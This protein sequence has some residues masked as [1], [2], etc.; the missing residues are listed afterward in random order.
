M[1]MYSEQ[2]ETPDELVKAMGWIWD[3]ENKYF[4]HPK[5][6]Q[7]LFNIFKLEQSKWLVPLYSDT[8]VVDKVTSRTFKYSLNSSG[9]SYSLE[10]NDP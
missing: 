1:I 3:E 9:N 7:F 4:K 2:Y 10:L 5:S 6:N 8:N